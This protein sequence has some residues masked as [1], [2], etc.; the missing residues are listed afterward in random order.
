MDLIRETFVN[1][2]T[3]SIESES[4]IKL[5]DAVEFRYVGISSAL[6][7]RPRLVHF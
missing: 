1:G 2:D 3:S 6:L 7:L 4:G 5:A